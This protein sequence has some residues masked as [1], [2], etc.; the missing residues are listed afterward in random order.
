[1]GL[2][3]APAAVEPELAFA[4]AGNLVAQAADD[5]PG[6]CAEK[7]VQAEMPVQLEG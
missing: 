5:Q 4:V 2:A 3:A 7:I 6:A 1:M